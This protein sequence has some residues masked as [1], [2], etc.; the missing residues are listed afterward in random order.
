[1]GSVTE[2]R[3]HN[4]VNELTARTVGQDPQI[5][6]TYDDAA[7]LTQDGSA[8]G[9]HQYV[10]DYRNRLIEVKEKQSGNWNTIAECKYDARTR[11]V[12][13][14]VT[15]KGSLNGTTRFLWGGDSDWQCLEERAGDGDLSARYTY[16]PVYIDAVPCRTRPERG[17]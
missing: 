6:L 2:T 10:W 5:S 15:N 3:V 1:V 16:A 17:W 7:N 12:L 14:A 11:R 4:A 8:D 9:D 13:K